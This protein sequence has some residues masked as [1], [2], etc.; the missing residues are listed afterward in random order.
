[1]TV[2]VGVRCSDGVVIGADSIATASMGQ[3]PLI[4]VEADP[5]IR[6]FN[7][8]VILATTG[9]VGY[10]QRLHFHVE[11]AIK[12]NVFNNFTAREATINISKRFVPDLHESKAPTW[13][14]EGY[15]FGGLMAATV[16]DGPFLAEFGTVDFQPELKAGKIF[17]GSLG[18]GQVLADPFLAFVCRV[19]WKNEMPDVDHGKFGVYW[20]FAHTIKL[21]P[22]KVGLPICLATLRQVAGKWVAEEK[23]T[24][25]SAQYIEELEGHIAK[26]A[27]APIEEATAEPVPQPDQKKNGS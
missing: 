20:V 8:A 7:D 26:F 18:F 23:D 16:K 27:Q 14:Q 25:E 6:I 9:A 15:R 4:Q 12:G 22:G 13:G 10:T 5:K 1:V 21:A 2:L 19:L 24:Q 17:F 11:A 3:F